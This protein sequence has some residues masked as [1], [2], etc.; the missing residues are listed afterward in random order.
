MTL[1]VTPPAQA[2]IHDPICGMEVDPAQAARAIERDG[3]TDY[4]CSTECGDVFSDRGPQ[5]PAVA[6]LELHV[7]AL[8]C[9]SC[10]GTVETAVGKLPGI[11]GVT[12][13]AVAGRVA[14]DCEPAYMS[15]AQLRSTITAAGYNVD[16]GGPTT[17]SAAEPGDREEEARHRDAARSPRGR[18]MR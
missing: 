8:D 3:K 12:A 6:H 17:E 9:A 2:A 5:Q 11:G 1:A 16:D 18:G 4:F 7:P 15:E 13:D 14:V 10:A